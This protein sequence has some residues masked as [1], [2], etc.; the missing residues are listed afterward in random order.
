MCPPNPE[1]ASFFFLGTGQHRVTNKN[2]IK[3][4]YEAT[5]D[6]YANTD[7]D[8]LSKTHVCL[9]DG[10][11]SNPN[12]MSSDLKYSQ[13]DREEHPIPG[14][15]IFNPENNKKIPIETTILPQNIKEL[16][17]R[18]NGTVAGEGIDEIL[19]EAILR[20][21]QLRKENKFPKEINLHGFSRGADTC[22]RLANLLDALYPQAP[23]L[24]V[25]L[26]LIDHV[27][28]PR[29]SEDPQAY[30]IPANV[31]HFESVTMLHEY[32]PYFNPQD[33]SRYV[34]ASPG[35]TQT[36][37]KVYPGGHGKGMN[38]G[39]NDAS[40][41]V[42]QLLHDDLFR[43]AKKTGSL[44]D[45]EQDPPDINKE[46]QFHVYET[47]PTHALE[48][49][50]RFTLYNEILE[51]WPH[52]S[53]GVRL[54][55][56]DIL[57]QYELNPQ[58]HLFVNQEH[59][60]LF[61]ALYPRTYNWF[62]KNSGNS[63]GLHKKEIEEL[64]KE[65]AQLKE[66]EN[67]S[68]TGALFYKR[69]CGYYK[70]K[71]NSFGPS[72]F[73]P[74]YDDHRSGT[75]LVTDELSYLKHAITSIIN[76]E[77]HH[78]KYHS[79]EN[80]VTLKLLNNSLKKAEFLPR[81]QACNIIKNSI[82]SSLNYLKSED[83]K[84]YLYQ[85]LFKLKLEI[86]PRKFEFDNLIKRYSEHISNQQKIHLDKASQDLALIEKTEL[87]YLQKFAES[88][89][90]IINAILHLQK[91]NEKEDEE[92]SPQVKELIS[93]LNQL[94]TSS[95]AAP[96]LASE[97]ANLFVA[98]SKRNLFWEMA[99]QI[100]SKIIPIESPFVSRK[101]SLISKEISDRL[102]NLDSQG[103]GN[104]LNKIYEILALGE[105]LLHKHQQN[106]FNKNHYLNKGD[107]DKILMVAKKR[108]IEQ[109]TGFGLANNTDIIES[110]ADFDEN[111]NK[112]N[113]LSFS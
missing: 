36:T 49:A 7:S 103:E 96:S 79:F 9:F 18:L 100:L 101:K 71:D 85:Q 13:Q 60:E 8:E 26:F 102:E 97:T 22:V 12:G 52:Y 70:I 91:Q 56:R 64:E 109:M 29:H 25:N 57:Q 83:H 48:D 41:Q 77:T 46:V 78:R 45:D 72:R 20:L 24:K 113:P 89:I 50:E 35:T 19:F 95:F 31:Q 80:N 5:E 66:L 59:A 62:Y 69:F 21:E 61:E 44:P 94:T 38:L 67:T 30:T 81:D 68:K 90:I 86:G 28:G 84:K 42:A 15:Y 54:N 34:F 39:I 104:N 10:V 11:G 23:E 51:N 63:P 98:Y 6:Y 112:P 58:H 3:T 111:D 93:E 14:S 88:K 16:M 4:F 1:I 75:P 27:S 37:F 43:F 99:Y 53:A 107:F 40:N 82:N 2:V 110:G 47:K 73:S 92:P 87:P 55:N 17:R 106:Y 76:Y 33:K 105:R 32:R 74:A 108:V 65:L